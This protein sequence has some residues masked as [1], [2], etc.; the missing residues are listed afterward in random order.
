LARGDT[1]QGMRTHQH[2]RDRPARPEI[3]VWRE[4]CLRADGFPAALAAPLAADL[5]VDV[6]ALIELRERGCPPALPA[7]ILAP[8]DGHG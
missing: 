2:P 4:R 3:V 5:R 6:H 7:R 1:N 8:L